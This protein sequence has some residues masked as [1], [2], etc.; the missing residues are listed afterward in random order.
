MR[1]ER[2]NAVPSSALQ[3]PSIPRAVLA[4][5]TC[6]CRCGS[7]S[8]E[9]RCG[10]WAAT[11][12]SPTIR[13]VPNS[14]GSADHLAVVRPAPH[15]ARLAL[16]PRQRFASAASHDLTHRLLNERVAERV[17]GRHR[18]RARRTISTKIVFSGCSDPATLDYVS[19][20]L[21]DEEVQRRSLSYDIAG[22]SGRRSISESTQ[23][24]ALTPFHLAP[25]GAS[26]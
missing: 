13:R 21:G 15:E 3:R 6:Q 14:A 25:P 11:K 18:L 19:R 22:G 2:Y 8:R 24:E 12:P 16:Q 9:V 10:N 1:C 4:T 17:H 7:P 5:R 26:G 23:R 20:L